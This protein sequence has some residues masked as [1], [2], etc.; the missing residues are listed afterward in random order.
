MEV[1]EAFK[2]VANRAPL[3]AVRDTC[4]VV[5]SGS[6]LPV[7]VTKHALCVGEGTSWYSFLPCG[8]P[9]GVDEIFLFWSHVKPLGPDLV[10]CKPQT[11]ALHHS[12]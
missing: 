2:R 11:T 8:A 9:V 10:L 12:C 6:V 4:V 7:S 1:V 3:D 5:A